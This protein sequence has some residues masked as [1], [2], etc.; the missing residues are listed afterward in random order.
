MKS[1]TKGHIEHLTKIENASHQ[2]K[3]CQAENLYPH[4]KDRELDP[5]T[6]A[7]LDSIKTRYDQ[8]KHSFNV[9]LQFTHATIHDKSLSNND[10]DGENEFVEVMKRFSEDFILFFFDFRDFLPD[11]DISVNSTETM[12]RRIQNRLRELTHK[13]TEAEK[14]VENLCTRFKSNSLSSST[15]TKTTMSSSST[16]ILHASDAQILSHLQT[17]HPKVVQIRVPPP[18]SANFSS[19][20]E[21][22]KQST[23]EIIKP[24]TPTMQ[25]S[26]PKSAN[27][28]TVESE[29]FKNM[30][31]LVRTS[32]DLFSGVTS[33]EQLQELSNTIATSPLSSAQKST[34]TPIT[35]TPTISKTTSHLKGNTTTISSKTLPT[36]NASM[37]ILQTPAK[38]VGA[39]VPIISV[40][41][42]TPASQGISSN[43]S[44]QL[45]PNR[46]A[47][48][49][50]TDATKTQFTSGD[51][52]IRSLLNNNVSPST[53]AVN[54]PI[55]NAAPVQMTGKHPF[56]SNPSSV[57][58]AL[59]TSQSFIAPS[60]TTTAV[61]APSS[62]PSSFGGSFHTAST[63]ATSI[64]SISP[65]TK[66]IM[67]T[68]FGSKPIIGG[69]ALNLTSTSPSTIPFGG[70]PT[71]ATAGTAGFGGMS[72]S[73]AS[74]L[75]A[76]FG[77]PASNISPATTSAP[78]TTT[79][80]APV[81]PIP[82]PTATTSAPTASPFGTFGTSAPT[83]SPFGALTT[84]ALTAAPFG[85]S[86]TSAPATNIF[87]SVIAP[88]ST[89]STFGTSP[90]SPASPFGSGFAN[91]LTT[92][93]SASN[94]G[95]IGGV[96]G[97]N[98]TATSPFGTGFNTTATTSSASSSGSSF[99]APSALSSGSTF[100]GFG[101][102]GFGL[103]LTSSAS[104]TI[105]TSTF[106]A[107]GNTGAFGSGFSGFGGQSNPSAPSTGFSFGGFG[108]PRSDSNAAPAS[109]G[110][111]GPPPAAS[112]PP[113][114][115]GASLFG[116]GGGGAASPPPAAF[117][118]KF[119]SI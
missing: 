78:S 15:F 104:S 110:S 98:I 48:S 51:N 18:V 20:D 71:T 40:T 58:T 109:F 49:T 31:R 119:S 92:T 66:P 96:F 4:L 88:T 73:T 118:S 86:T 93:T 61:F 79:S 75:N 107:G 90:A 16:P 56:F 115:F 52:A 85:V 1:M 10:E 95:T 116:G 108:G 45:Q 3:L 53:S 69:I 13:V 112:Q 2:I 87:G 22:K 67:S 41:P 26:T 7:R 62:T 44:F 101:G 37:N 77:A 11:F 57:S 14:Q 70:T 27:T 99:G 91:T 21:Q 38:S 64:Q 114:P 35:K 117:G 17:F 29:G 94:T 8:V 28:S 72:S 19:S 34:V 24:V 74:P 46:S 63:A 81:I 100:G 80:S 36:G 65:T 105:P 32:I 9:L 103:N 47:V 54:Q 76:F 97:G 84:S 42:P 6:Q 39:P 25:P 106:G 68:G 60:T 43:A 55:V 59:T 89:S 5:W 33:P 82:I 30:L 83:A 113:S 23:I 102:T 12:K 111:F 50:A